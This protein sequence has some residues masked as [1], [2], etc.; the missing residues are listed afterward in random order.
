[1][2]FKFKIQDYQTEA[3][4]NTIRVFNGQ[5]KH[6]VSDGK[7]NVARRKRRRWEQTAITDTEDLAGYAN[8]AL[9]LSD[10]DLLS[11]I[12]SVQ[13]RYMLDH[14]QELSKPIKW[15]RGN[16]KYSCPGLDIE[17]ETGTGKTYVYIKTIYE[18]NRQYGWTKFIIVVP[19]IAIREGVEKSF[20]YLNEHFASQYSKQAHHFIYN[21]QNL[22]D[23]RDFEQ[24]ADIQ[25]MIINTQA[26]ASSLKEGANNKEARIIYSKRDD[27]ESRRPIDLIKGTRP[28]LILDE[29]QKMGGTA[30]Q[31]GFEQFEPLFALYYSATHKDRHNIVYSL[32]AKDAFEKKLVKLIEVKGFEVKNL[33]GSEA[34]IYFDRV[35]LSKNEAPTVRLELDVNYENGKKREFRKVSRNTNLYDITKL[36]AYKDLVVKDIDPENGIVYFSD[37]SFLKRGDFKGDT[38][39]KALK[40]IQIIETINSHFDKEKN[41][42]SRGI[43]TLSL[44]FIDEVAN[45][46]WYNDEGER[47]DGPFAE[48]FEYEYNRILNERLSEFSDDYKNYLLGLDVKAIHNG[49]FSI[50]KK[51]R[52]IDSKVKRGDSISDDISAYDLILKDKERLLSFSEPTRFIFS[53]SALREGWDNPNVFQICTLRHTNSAITKRQEVGRGLRICVDQNG[54]RMD[55]Q[56]L[57]DDM[58]NINVLT[59]ISNESYSNFVKE[60]QKEISDVVKYKI[61]VI[62]ENSFNGKILK[63]ETEEIKITHIQACSIVAYL[64]DWEYID[65]DGNVTDN[66]RKAVESGKLEGMSPKIAKFHDIVVDVVK[67]CYNSQIDITKYVTD[68]N[69]S[70]VANKRNDANFFKQEFIDLWN[71]INHKYVYTVHYNSDELIQKSIASINDKLFISKLKSL[72]TKGKQQDTNSFGNETTNTRTIENEF[73]S[74][75]KYDLVGDIAQG[76]T[77]TRRT[78][79]NILKGISKEKLM[80]FRNN[81]EEFISEVIKLIKDEKATMFVDH[82]SYNITDQVYDSDIFTKD[83]NIFTKDSHEY[84]KNKAYLAKKHIL[85]YVITDGLSDNN[86]ERKFAEALDKAG[87]VCVYAKLPRSFQ[88]PTPVGNYSPDWAIAFN[89]GTVKHIFFVAETK[90]SMNDFNLKKVELG[91]INCAKILFNKCSDQNVKYWNVATYQDLLDA[92]GKVG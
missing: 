4:E 83:K 40:R 62:T 5:T 85:D 50:D 36:N 61:S 38:N 75:V 45:Y 19:S 79:V 70:T 2:K 9:E 78:I 55:Y 11:N 51:G 14:S 12:Q 68:G 46:R 22:Q 60:L 58:H 41:L 47:F 69:K 26:F 67:S 30:T 8:S 59:L 18:L 82:I 27:M 33:T 87:E 72:M 15:Q 66:G 54:K 88:I 37:D 43:K 44:F 73:V 65:E 80:L 90:G 23:I 77:L 71:R 32:D 34:Y 39:D 17:M 92:M 20:G 48:I 81:P 53:H 56:E 76:T 52:S 16:A 74:N 84:P 25:V 86:V 91:K 3:V 42:Y 35:D 63:T 24:S 28:I 49:Y 10:E 57:G 89:K 7:F 1:M 64:N 13:D 31:K 29:P 21:S 6:D